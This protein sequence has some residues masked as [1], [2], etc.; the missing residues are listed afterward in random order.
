MTTQEIAGVTTLVVDR[1]GPMIDTRQAAVDVVGDA[2]STRAKLV[3]IPVE[4]LTPAF[5][6]LRTGL[7]GEVA[8]AF[9]NYGLNLAIVGDVSAEVERSAPLADWVRECNRGAQV[10]FVPTLDALAERLGAQM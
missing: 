4:R 9:V 7:A 8:Q 3:A 6:Q 10:W 1:E 2:L 5:F